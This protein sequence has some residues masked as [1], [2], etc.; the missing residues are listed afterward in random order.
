MSNT[1]NVFEELGKYFNPQNEK[2]TIATDEQPKSTPLMDAC[3]EFETRFNNRELLS[4]CVLSIHNKSGRDVTYKITGTTYPDD[5][6][7]F[8]V[9]LYYNHPSSKRIGIIVKADKYYI[10]MADNIS[11]ALNDIEHFANLNLN[12]PF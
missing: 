2:A 8:T 6:N 1:I 3:K 4:E 11:V 9:R 7:Y 12:L 10:S 5:N